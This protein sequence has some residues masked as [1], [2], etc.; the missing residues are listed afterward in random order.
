MFSRKSY[1]LI[2]YLLTPADSIQGAGNLEAGQTYLYAQNID[3]VNTSGI[4][5]EGVFSYETGYA[6]GIRV[7]I[8]YTLLDTKSGDAVVSKY[9]STHSGQLLKGGFSLSW[10]NVHLYTGFLW[11]QRDPEKA[12][13]INA[14]LNDSYTLWNV[15]LDKYFLDERIIATFQ[16]DNLFDETYEDILGAVM[17]G[18]WIHGGLILRFGAQD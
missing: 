2:D 1:N 10:K 4:E 16:V 15:K 14:T 12:E 7:R 9:V 8:A 3:L 17:P 18:R 6:L 11:K 13:A 5:T